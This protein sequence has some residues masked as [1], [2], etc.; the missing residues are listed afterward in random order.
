MKR[1]LAVLFLICLLI[2][3]ASSEIVEEVEFIPGEAQPLMGAGVF[4]VQLT[5]EYADKEVFGGRCLE[6]PIIIYNYSNDTDFGMIINKIIVNG[7]DI[8]VKVPMYQ[9]V[10]AKGKRMDTLMVYYTEAGIQAKEEIESIVFRVSLYDKNHRDYGA[11]D[12]VNLTFNWG[13]E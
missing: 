2:P 3:Y 7:W 8:S 12:P 13:G 9:L 6:L 5:G 11:F 1:I 4:D 10:S